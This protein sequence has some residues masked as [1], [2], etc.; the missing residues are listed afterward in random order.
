MGNTDMSLLKHTVSDS[1]SVVCVICDFKFTVLLIDQY[2]TLLGTDGNNGL[3]TP[4]NM[5]NS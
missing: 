2:G 5:M 4:Y 3:S 1:V